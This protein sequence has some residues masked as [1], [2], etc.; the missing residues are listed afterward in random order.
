MATTS[1][2]NQQPSTSKEKSG[3]YQP[4]P[5][6]SATSGDE[7]SQNVSIQTIQLD[8]SRRPKV[9]E[10]SP[11][12]SEPSSSDDSG[13][14]DRRGGRGDRRQRRR[15]PAMFP[16]HDIAPPQTPHINANLDKKINSIKTIT[17]TFSGEDPD[18]DVYDFI[19]RLTETFSMYSEDQLNDNDKCVILQC[20]LGK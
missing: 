17:G 3:L 5:R 4:A 20:L 9:R 14:G 15:R 8:H 11:S 7:S 2:L 19:A 1:Q 12:S 18:D 6:K 13:D 10:T 16:S